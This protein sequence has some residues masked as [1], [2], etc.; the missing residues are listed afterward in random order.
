VVAEA[1]LARRLWKGAKGELYQGD[2]EQ[3]Q[4]YKDYKLSANTYL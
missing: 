2:S 3:E 1:I 4:N